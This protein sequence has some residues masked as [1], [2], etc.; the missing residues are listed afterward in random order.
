M[1]VWEEGLLSSGYH[2][3]S[4]DSGETIVED[5]KDSENCPPAVQPRVP[6]GSLVQ[7]VS[8]CWSLTQR[9]GE[10]HGGKAERV[11]EKG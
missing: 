3:I 8:L 7:G 9:S 1:K 11:S 5:R 2:R 10:E 6:W 4:S